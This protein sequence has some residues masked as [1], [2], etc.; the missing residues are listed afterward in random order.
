MGAPD[1]R[2]LDPMP[3]RNLSGQGFTQ[4][5]EF[6]QRLSGE[7]VLEDGLGGSRRIDG[8]QRA[9]LTEQDGGERP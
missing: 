2:A 4:R 8:P 9:L 5:H 7:A 1:S 6:I 3:A